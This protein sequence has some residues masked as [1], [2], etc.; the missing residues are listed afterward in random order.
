[1]E[2]MRAPD[3]VLRLTNTEVDNYIIL[4]SLIIISIMLKSILRLLNHILYLILIH[5]INNV[6]PI[7]LPS[8]TP[9]VHNSQVILLTLAFH[10]L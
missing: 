8:G 3:A 4:S 10:H 2:K 7:T 9:Q 6:E 1:M 5:I